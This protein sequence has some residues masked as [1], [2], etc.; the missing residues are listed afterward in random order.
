[1]W[2]KQEISVLFSYS[3]RER[4]CR[5]YFP[6]CPTDERL[7]IR[8]V[9]MWH[10]AKY[11]QFSSLISVAVYLMRADVYRLCYCVPSCLPRGEH[12]FVCRTPQA[13]S[14]SRYCTRSSIHALKSINKYLS[15]WLFKIKCDCIAPF[16]ESRLFAWEAA[17][18]FVPIL[19]VCYYW[20]WI[21]LTRPLCHVNHHP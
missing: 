13:P 2:R 21:G 14:R 18:E 8:C 1:M 10:Y 19:F 12:S 3:F 16:L 5:T 9:W 17:L 7:Y 15:E 11:V 4:K 20:S 6:F